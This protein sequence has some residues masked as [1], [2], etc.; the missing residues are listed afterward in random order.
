MPSVSNDSAS[1]LAPRPGLAL[2]ELRRSSVIESPV[3]CESGEEPI[4]SS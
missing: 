2:G 4:I 3:I 1:L